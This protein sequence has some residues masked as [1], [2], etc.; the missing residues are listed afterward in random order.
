[1]PFSSLETLRHLLIAGHVGD[2]TNG[3]V[4]QGGLE[5]LGDQL[6][7]VSRLHRVDGI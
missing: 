2:V 1:M 5:E 6:A 4:R 3:T 7:D